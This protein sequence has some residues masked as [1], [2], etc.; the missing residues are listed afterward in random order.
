M[1][2]TPVVVES[3]STSERLRLEGGQTILEGWALV[4]VD[5][6]HSERFLHSQLTSDVVGQESGTS[7]LSA[8]LDGS[9]RVQSFFYVARYDDHLLLLVPEVI[10]VATVQRLESHVIADDVRLRLQPVGRMWL[11]LGPEAAKM[12]EA[13]ASETLFPVEG[14]GES[15]S[16]S[17][18]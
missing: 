6:R 18:E 1:R 15:G 4:R 2:P 12:Q 5:G 13:L 9:G 3:R 17:V 16:I 8:L 10:V 7:R 11:A 14:W